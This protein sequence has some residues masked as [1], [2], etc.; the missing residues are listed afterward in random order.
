[1]PRSTVKYAF[2]HG[3]L[4]WASGFREGDGFLAVFGP[5][6][7]I[8]EVYVAEGAARSGR[9]LVSHELKERVAQVQPRWMYYDPFD[10]PEYAWLEWK[11]VPRA[12]LEKM[13]GAE[14][15]K[16]LAA[17]A[18]GPKEFPESWSVMF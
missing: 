8:V 17:G 10:W 1:M 18:S 13:L 4:A 15:M 12:A 5:T 9:R 11:D 3:L 16:A 14:W 2:E 6:G 7:E